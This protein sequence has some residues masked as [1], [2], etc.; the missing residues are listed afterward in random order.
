MSP[1]IFALVCLV[2]AVRCIEEVA[3]TS[4][5][6][7]RLKMLTSVLANDHFWK[8]VFNQHVYVDYHDHY[9]LVIV[10]QLMAGAKLNAT[11]GETASQP[12]TPSTSSEAAVTTKTPIRPRVFFRNLF[13][14]SQRYRVGSI[15]KLAVKIVQ[16][17]FLCLSYKHAVHLLKVI[18][19]GLSRGSG[20]ASSWSSKAIPSLAAIIMRMSELEYVDGNLLRTEKLF[21]MYQNKR[22]KKNTLNKFLYT[23]TLE[24]ISKTMREYIKDNCVKNPATEELIADEL[25]VFHTSSLYDVGEARDLED[26]TFKNMF[27]SSINKMGSQV[28]NIPYTAGMSTEMWNGFLHSSTDENEDVDFV[29][30]KR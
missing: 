4:D 7:K 25:N 6:N 12:E 3:I 15:L 20:K 17:A 1:V 5:Y 18:R 8:S 13:L 11:G 9:H 23:A 22:T 2:S 16:N 28:G 30:I 14:R 26:K 19:V 24:R 10:E 27:V 29:E 21:Y